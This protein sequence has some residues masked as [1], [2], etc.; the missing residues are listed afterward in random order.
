VSIRG[1]DRGKKGWW[2]AVLGSCLL[3]GY[4]FLPCLQPSNSFGRIYAV[5]GGFFIVLSFLLGWA[6]DGDRPDIGDAV[7]GVIVLVGVLLMMLWPR[8]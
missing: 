8:N 4:G 1:N 7:G 6:L 2:F 5:Y 3:I